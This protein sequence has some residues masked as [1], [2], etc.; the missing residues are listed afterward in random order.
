MSAD[1]F[2]DEPVM[3]FATPAAWRA[4]LAEHHATHRGFWMRIHHKASGEPTV[5]YAEALDEALCYGWI[6]GQKNKDGAGSFLQ[7]FTPRKPRSPWSQRN[8]EH[9]ARLE[10][11]GRMTPAGRREV[12]AARADGRWEAAYAPQ[13]TMEEPA[14]LRAALDADPGARAFFDGL[15][16]AQRYAFCYRI[17][18][19]KRPETRAKRLAWALELIGRREKP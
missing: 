1:T 2:K 11:A 16:R 3:A 5:T 17:T 9:V 14:E 7:R 8:R 15:T 18:T 12:E 19:A 6:D 4:W 13:S 10:A